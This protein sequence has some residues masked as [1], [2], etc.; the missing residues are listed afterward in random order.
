MLEEVTGKRFT[1]LHIVGGGSQNY[2]LNQL[3]ANATGLPV[4]AGPV[5]ATA[6]GNILTQA[7]STGAIP[8]LQ[9]ARALVARSAGIQR[10]DP[11]R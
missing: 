7:L 2:L 3:A 10:F 11:Q 1:T 9:E 5:E 6:M 8:S 4:L